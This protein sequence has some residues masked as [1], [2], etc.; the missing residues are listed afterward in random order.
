[1]LQKKGDARPCD[2]WRL[3]ISGTLFALSQHFS[4]QGRSEG[5]TQNVPRKISVC[6]TWLT[7]PMANRLKLLGITYLIGKIWFKL[8]FHG[9][10]AE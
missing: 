6:Y 5:G 1:M 3:W 7:Q 10:L 9:P 4:C 2:E 8:L